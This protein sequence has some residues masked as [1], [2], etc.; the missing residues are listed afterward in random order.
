VS[1]CNTLEREGD[2]LLPNLDAD[3]D[4]VCLLV[5][6]PGAAAAPLQGKEQPVEHMKATAL[7]R[8][9]E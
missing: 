5:P 6:Y 2:V 7:K 8:W 3:V 4:V 1:S 9:L